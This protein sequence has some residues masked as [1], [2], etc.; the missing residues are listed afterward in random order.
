MKKLLNN[1]CACAILLT[2]GITGCKKQTEQLAVTP[3][4]DYTALQPGKVLIYHL[5]S[6]LLDASGS[7][8]VNAA[9][10][11]KDSTGGQYTDNTG[12]PSYT[13]FRFI[14]DTLNA[15][16]WQPLL[17][18]YITPTSTAVETVDDNNL[19]FVSLAQPVQEGFT[20]NGT[21]YIDTRSATSNYQYMDGWQFAYQN[22][23]KPYTVLKGA[24]DSTVTV[25]QVDDT[26]PPG[27]FDPDSY[28]QRNYSTE[29][30][31]KGVGLIYKEFLHWTWQPTPEPAQ[32][33]KDS[34]GIKLNLIAVK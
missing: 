10:L 12:R 26:S 34:Y 9:Y 31:A 29:V 30:Y 19:R 4:S 13:I 3:L 33:Q 1:I 23:N 25:L 22:V 14:T 21:T 15:N 27:P 20:W 7:Q 8:L 11:V 2:I 18:Y 32:Y 28:Q 16:P 5:D 24:I 6:T 17:T